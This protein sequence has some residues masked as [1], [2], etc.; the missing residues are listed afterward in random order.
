MLSPKA[1]FC[2]WSDSR[3]GNLGSYSRNY[4]LVDLHDDAPL[5]GECIE[6]SRFI[7]SRILAFISNK[8]K[9]L[10][11]DLS[12]TT[13]KKKNPIMFHVKVH[14]RCF[15]Q[16]ICLDVDHRV[17]VRRTHLWS[18]EHRG[19]SDRIEWTKL[20]FLSSITDRCQS[21]SSGSKFTSYSLILINAW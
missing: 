2:F 1:H 5:G 7:V 8:S 21:K 18:R 16:G 19:Y 10:L 20:T 15:H 4:S 17:I 13:P 6:Q 14:L 3:E 9:I 11:T 12:W